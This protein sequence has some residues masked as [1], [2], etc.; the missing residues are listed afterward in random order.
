MADKKYELTFALSDGSNEKVQFTAPQGP[1]GQ[2]GA[3]GD[4]GEKG[5]T[6]ATGPQGPKGDTGATGAAGA[7]GADGEDG[8]YYSP[9]VDSSGNLSWT[10]SKTLMPVPATV[11]I[12]GPKGDTGAKGAT[13]ATGPQGATGATG[14]DGFSPVVTLTD[15]EE[16]TGDTGVTIAVTNKNGTTTTKKVYNGTDGFIGP[17]GPAGEDAGP[18]ELIGSWVNGGSLSAT[19]T[20]YNE[21]MFVYD[22]QNDNCYGGAASVLIP[23]AKL[24]S[25]TKAYFSCLYST[26]VQFVVE[27]NTTTAKTYKA[28]YSGATNTAYKIFCYGR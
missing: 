12:K 9:S 26:N 19:F 20:N 4:A 18:W 2:Q 27:V 28:T 23:T 17:Q 13:G 21:I 7:D 1:Q 24:P 25:S 5:A 6:G 22:S 15:F 11:N 14:A 3:K 10:P 16:G 8:G